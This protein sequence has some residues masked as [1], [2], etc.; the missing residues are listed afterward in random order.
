MH[1]RRQL[2]HAHS[3]ANLQSQRHQGLPCIRKPLASDNPVHCLPQHNETGSFLSTCSAQIQSSID[4]IHM[5]TDT[6]CVTY[7][8]LDVTYKVPRHDV[9]FKLI[10]KS[11]HHINMAIT[12]G[13]VQ[14]ISST[15][16]ETKWLD[17]YR[18]YPCTYMLTCITIHTYVH[19]AIRLGM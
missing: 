6:I 12:A 11:S 14:C 10:N 16:E 1:C 2:L 18:H 13:K 5:T 7:K 17:I 8:M 19:T 4:Y 3:T 15:L 9:H